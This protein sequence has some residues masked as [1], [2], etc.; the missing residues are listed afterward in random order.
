MSAETTLIEDAVA[1]LSREVTAQCLPSTA[2]Y[3]RLVR[4][5]RSLPRIYD[6]TGAHAMPLTV[7]LSARTFVSQHSIYCVS[8][9]PSSLCRPQINKHKTTFQSKA[10]HAR[11]RAFSYACSLPVTWKIWRSHHSIRHSRK[12]HAIRKL[13]G[14]M[15]GSTLYN[16][17]SK[18]YLVG[19]GIFDL[20]APVTL[21]LTSWPSYTNLTC[22]S[23][24]CT[25][26]EV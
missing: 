16:C 15:L 1:Y 25:A 14:S 23:W 18:F 10:N 24:R 4:G 8:T 9:S 17:R 21:T 26:C 12:T 11:M 22:I 19:M 20:F 7:G 6:A 3:R 2:F 13:R 5:M